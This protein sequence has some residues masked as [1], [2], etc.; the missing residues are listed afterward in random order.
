MQLQADLAGVSVQVPSD[1]EAT[2]RGAA[3]L[4]G[5]GVGLFSE[6]PAPEGTTRVFTASTTPEERAQR[7]QDW[8]AAVA[9]VRS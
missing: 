5:V 4:A 6:P 2:A 1:L 8:R 3:A 7:L 9:R